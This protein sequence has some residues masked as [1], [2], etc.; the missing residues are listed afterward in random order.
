MNE[1]KFLLVGMPREDS[2]WLHLDKHHHAGISF[3]HKGKLKQ[4]HFPADWITS[5]LWYLKVG[6]F[7]N[8]EKSR[9]KGPTLKSIVELSLK[10]VFCAVINRNHT[11]LA[12]SM[13][14]IYGHQLING[15]PSISYN[16]E[17]TLGRMLARESFTDHYYMLGITNQ[18]I[19]KPVLQ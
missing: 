3:W 9:L 12:E 4:L 16:V 7:P 8:V 1:M 18:Q 19:C 14:S 5:R 10:R 2:V 6:K 15:A 17:G 13:C 11:L